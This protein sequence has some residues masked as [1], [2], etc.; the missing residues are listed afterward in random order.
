MKQEEFHPHYRLKF[1]QYLAT[2]FIFHWSS[3][4]ILAE[5][6]SLISGLVDGG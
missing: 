4:L 2:L 3:R 5:A 6:G 1:F